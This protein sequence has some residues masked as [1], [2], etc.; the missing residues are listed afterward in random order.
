MVVL[1]GLTINLPNRYEIAMKHTL[2]ILLISGL[3]AC[4]TTTTAPDDT[5]GSDQTVSEDSSSP[6]DDQGS[7]L[8][9]TANWCETIQSGPAGTRP[10]PQDFARAH[11]GQRL[12]APKADWLTADEK[13]ISLLHDNELDPDLLP[14]Y[15]A[16]FDHICATST[17]TAPVPETLLTMLDTFAVIT[18]GTGT[19]DIPDEALVLV[20]DLRDLH[21][22]A[23]VAK[24]AAHA[25]SSHYLFGQR[26]VRR[27]L[28]F[29]SQDDG[30]THYESSL[31]DVPLSLPPAGN[32]EMPILFLVGPQLTPE[33]ATIAGG[34][35]L[36]QRAALLGHDIHTKVAESTFLGIGDQGLVWRNSELWLDAGVW[37]DRIPADIPTSEPEAVLGTLNPDA[38]ESLL[39]SD[40]KPVNP[41]EITR[42]SIESYTRYPGDP[43]PNLDH[44]TMQAAL[45]VAYGTLDWFYPYF[46]IVGRDIDGALLDGLDEVSALPIGDRK[47]MKH[48][49]GRFMHHIHDGHGFYTDH[50]E[51]MDDWPDGYL[52][53][54]IQNVNGEAVIRSSAHDGLNAGDTILAVDGVTIE[55]WY[56]E[57]MTRYSASSDGY[58]FVLASD[59][60]KE[61]YGTKTLSVRDPDGVERDV[62]AQPS[63]DI[64]DV[65]WGG[66]L[67]ESG[68]LTDLDAPGIYYVNMSGEVTPDITDLMEGF[69]DVVDA[70]GFV[71][72]MRDY[73]YLDIYGFAGHFNPD[74]FTAPIFG[75][76]TWTGPETFAIEDEIWDFPPANQVYT[77][78]IVLLVSNKSVSAA[79]C[80]GQ[81]IMGLSNVTVIGQTSACTNGTI[82]N[83][84]L[85]GNLGITF[86]GMRLRNLDGTE[87]HGIGIIP[88]ETVV[89][90]ATDFAAGT[91][92]ELMRALEVLLSP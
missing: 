81:M 37:P 64:Y 78:P 10:F 83:V 21:P 68:W 88:D 28:G 72:D 51:D 18:P 34:L 92:P 35:R 52:I 45:L 69:S 76:P 75:H 29:P 9:P 54:Q 70:S 19:V 62:T 11:V 7:G 61:V 25:M 23:D 30:W 31:E 55:D 86:T 53:V 77:G 59:E 44:A 1:G 16:Q 80:F 66:S 38:I 32:R 41:S 46:D 58:R 42:P 2:Y 3:L 39:E 12:F 79:E 50:S 14:L 43:A 24:A 49:M 87:F 36:S 74:P 33:A 27:F 13:L 20:V 65:A 40:L 5:T 67:R 85:P 60:L 47:G 63:W 15:A 89:P 91:D 73:P 57:A 48:V 82:T 4:G 8:P 22:E 26:R 56:A 90:D 71:L 84:L 6:P 17:I